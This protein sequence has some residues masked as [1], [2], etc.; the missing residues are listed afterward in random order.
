[1]GL[2]SANGVFTAL[3]NGTGAI[4]V[5]THGLRAA[6]AF[7]A[8]V[9]EELMQQFLYSIGLNVYPQTLSLATAVGLRQLKV[10][11]ASQVDLSQSSSGTSYFVSD[12]KVLNVTADGLVTA[13][14]PGKAT[15]TIINGPAEFVLTVFVE[16]P[17]IGPTTLGN[18]GGVVQGND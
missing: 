8:G 4:V 1:A 16:V 11:L 18:A 13:L 14:L 10:D 17:H 5:T 15:V 12:S 3:T 2:V 7:S 9:P 6:T